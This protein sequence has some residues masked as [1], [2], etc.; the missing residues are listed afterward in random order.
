MHLLMPWC[1]V[2]N[3]NLQ[4]GGEIIELQG[5]MAQFSLV[6]KKIDFVASIRRIHNTNFGRTSSKKEFENYALILRK[7]LIQRAEFK[8]NNQ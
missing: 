8:R 3:F 1:S 4:Y 5:K 2:S 7:R 6:M